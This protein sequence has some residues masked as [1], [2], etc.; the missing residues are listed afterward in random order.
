[1]CKVFEKIAASVLQK[2]GAG[3]QAWKA[4]PWLQRACDTHRCKSITTA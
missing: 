1:M 4:A 3:I 2:I